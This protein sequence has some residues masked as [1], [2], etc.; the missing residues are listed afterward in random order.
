MIWKKILKES[1]AQDDPFHPDYVDP[2]TDEEI[3][4]LVEG[5]VK[6]F[7]WTRENKWNEYMG[8]G[9]NAGEP[10]DYLPEEQQDPN[11]PNFIGD[12]DGINIPYPHTREEILQQIKSGEKF[13]AQEFY[14]F[15]DDGPFYDNAVS[16]S[17]ADVKDVKLPKKEYPNNDDAWFEILSDYVRELAKVGK[18]T[19]IIDKY[20]TEEIESTYHPKL[21]EKMNIKKMSWKN[22][23]KSKGD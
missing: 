14:D 19:S 12:Y 9:F 3:R 21:K 6:F 4:Y 7:L 8:F 15:A 22:V 23:I 11:N 16:F 10:L 2:M 17:L 18:I 5:W 20:F 13:T 1:M